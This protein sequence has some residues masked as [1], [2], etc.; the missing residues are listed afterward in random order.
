LRLIQYVKENGHPI[1]C[2]I[3]DGKNK[4]GWSL[5]NED[6]GDRF[7]KDRAVLIASGR[8]KPLDET[9]DFF[10]RKFNARLG[11]EWLVEDMLK[12]FPR[13]GH[14][15]LEIISISNRAEKYFKTEI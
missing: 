15:F 9:L 13:A 7:C 1:G 12:S 14:L 4:F 3:A 11:E 5:V 2:V 6:L 8:I 10:I